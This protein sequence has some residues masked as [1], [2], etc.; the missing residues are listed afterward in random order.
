MGLKDA[1]IRAGLIPSDD[2]EQKT[3]KRYSEMLSHELAIEVADGLRER[4]FSAMKP[5]R[6]I[7]TRERGKVKF[8]S[9]KRRSSREGSAPREWTSRFRTTDMA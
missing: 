7:I 9:G 3:K 8:R 1:V 6:E 5:F 2:V 4:G